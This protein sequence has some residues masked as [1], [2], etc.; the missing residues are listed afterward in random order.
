MAKIPSVVLHRP[1]AA[2][3]RPCEAC[4]AEMAAEVVNAYSLL[5]WR[6]GGGGRTR[7]ASVLFDYASSSVVCVPGRDPTVA[8]V[9]RSGTH[10]YV[11]EYV[12]LEYG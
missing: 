3:A 5:S 7:G 4:D 11:Y 10:K 6:H 12:L 2:R 9:I 8:Y 1:R